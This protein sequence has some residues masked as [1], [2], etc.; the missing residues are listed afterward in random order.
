MDE[1]LKALRP[2]KSPYLV[3]GD[4]SK[5]AKRGKKL[6]ESA[7][8]AACHNGAYLTDMKLHAVGATADYPEN[9]RFD[10]PTLIEVWRTA[11]FLYDGRAE[12]LKEMMIKFND[13]DR[14]G[15]TRQLNKKQLNDLTE[16]IL[17][18]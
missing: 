9:Q 15:I 3:N 16:Y 8:C 4:L 2:V 10:T 12:T 11:P 13:G 17:S 18:L 1:Y 5:A 7:G 6:F 14:H